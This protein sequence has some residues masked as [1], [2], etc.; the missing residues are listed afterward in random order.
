MPTT[1]VL[2]ARWYDTPNIHLC[3]IL[4]FEDMAA[5][6]GI[7]IERALVLDSRRQSEGSEFDATRQL[8]RGAMHRA[9]PAR[10][11]QSNAVLF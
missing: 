11:R 5:E 1:Q 3:T 9:A 7:T 2:P 10:L 8:V 6:L 4:D